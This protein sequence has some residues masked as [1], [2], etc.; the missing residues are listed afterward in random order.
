VASLSAREAD[1]LWTRTGRGTGRFAP[2]PAFLPVPVLAGAAAFAVL[3]LAVSLFSGGPH[4]PIWSRPAVEVGSVAGPGSLKLA[5]A[6]ALE[7]ECGFNAWPVTV[8]EFDSLGELLRVTTNGG[9]QLALV[10][11]RR[12]GTRALLVGAG[13]PGGEPATVRLDL[14]EW[15]ACGRAVAVSCW[16]YAPGE[17]VTV[18]LGAHTSSGE[19]LEGKPAREVVPGKW[20]WVV[21]SLPGAR[22]RI[23]D[24]TIT[25]HGDSPARLDRMELWCAQDGNGG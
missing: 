3:L 25:L 12:S 20:S 1:R 23:T 17:P 6:G 21:F 16:V 18:T 13:S 9:R 2:R 5:E 14:P 22:G 15:Q 19:E 10:P 7:K 24:L 4:A 11:D 8:A